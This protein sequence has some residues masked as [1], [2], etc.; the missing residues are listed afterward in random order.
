MH[1]SACAV[2]TKRCYF[3]G[4]SVSELVSR[5]HGET[6]GLVFPPFHLDLETEQL[7]HADEL[8]ALRPKTFAVLRYLVEHPDCL[9][10]KDELL[11]AVWAGTIVSDTVLTTSYQ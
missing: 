3:G 4:I 9:V 6:D 5:G 8:I 7:W 2:I 1:C 11:D 10:T